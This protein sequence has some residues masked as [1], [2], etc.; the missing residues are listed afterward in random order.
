MPNPIL[1]DLPSPLE[2]PRLVLRPPQPGD[3]Q[4]LFGAITESLPELRRFL[5]NLPWVAAD[6]TL[7]SSE[8]YCR[9]G[10]SNFLA[11]KDLPIGSS[12]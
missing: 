12:G 5:A 3:G 9:T 2:T 11:R 1:F 6:Q 7:E 8:I 10:Q 4:A